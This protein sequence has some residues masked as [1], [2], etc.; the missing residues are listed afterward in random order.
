MSRAVVA[1][2]LGDAQLIR[3]GYFSLGCEMALIRVQ[4]VAH[5]ALEYCLA[6]IQPKAHVAQFQ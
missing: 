4:N 2:G 5:V 1:V 6:V 3:D